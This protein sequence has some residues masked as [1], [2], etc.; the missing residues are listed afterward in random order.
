MPTAMRLAT[1]SD[2]DAVLE[3]L[4]PVIRDT[5]ISF[6]LTPPS[7]ETVRGRIRDVLRL[8]P[9]LVLEEDG[10]VLGYASARRRNSGLERADPR[11]PRRERAQRGREPAAGVRVERGRDERE[12]GFVLGPSV[13]RLVEELDLG[14]ED[15]EAA[16]LERQLGDRPADRPV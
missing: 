11:V 14:P 6:E 7:V 10:T 8:A 1:E 5:V 16:D 4:A 13:L 12:V 3:I 15:G 9:W 2:A